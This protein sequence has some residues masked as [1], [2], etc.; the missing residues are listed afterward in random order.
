M[1]GPGEVDRLTVGVAFQVDAASEARAKAAAVAVEE[2]GDEAD[3]ESE[4]VVEAVEEAKREAGRSRLPVKRA[5]DP[6]KATKAKKAAKRG[7]KRR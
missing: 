6:R 3:P 1:L 2:A 7:G 5:R 4:A